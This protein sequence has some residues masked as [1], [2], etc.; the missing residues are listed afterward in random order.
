MTCTFRY[1]LSAAAE[2]AK[3]G[4]EGRENELRRW[5]KSPGLV[6]GCVFAALIASPASANPPTTTAWVE[7]VGTREATLKTKINPEGFATTYRVEWGIGASF[8]K[9]TEE[10]FVGSDNAD[11]LMSLFLDKLEP[12]TAYRW[13]VIATNATGGSKGKEESFRTF[14]APSPLANCPNEALRVGLS[15]NLPDCRAYE[16]V[17]PL[18][19]NGGNAQALPPAES[20]DGIYTSFKQSSFDGEKLTY[21]SGTAFGDAVAGAWANQYIATRDIDGWTTHGISPPRG[22]A[23]FEGQ[24]ATP[25]VNWDTENLFEAFTPDLCS[26]WVKDTNSE[27]LAPGGLTGY[28]NIY[29]RGNCGR[30]GYEALTM[31]GPFGPASEYLND[32]SE[33]TTPPPPPGP[34][35][36]FQ[37]YSADLTHQLFISGANLT[38]ERVRAGFKAECINTTLGVFPSSVSF[39][40][41]RNGVSID[42][43][44][45]PAYT[46]TSADQ[47]TTIQC[48]IFVSNASAGSTQIAVPPGGWVVAPVPESAPP[49]A[50]PTI[51]P[52]S[53]SAPLAVGGPGGQ[54]LTCDPK[55]KG[56]RG[57]P[58]FTYQWYRNGL[59]IVGATA[60]TYSV[61]PGDLATRA[62]F[63]CAVTG[64]NAG[65]A[66]VKVSANRATEPGPAK[67][68]APS[69]D[70][71]VRTKTQLYDLHDGKLELVSV[72]PSGEPNP[73]NSVAGTLGSRNSNR[74]STLGHAISADGSRIFWT[75]RSGDLTEGIGKLFV[76]IDG[77]RTLPVSEAVSPDGL[78][79]FLTAAKDGSSVLFTM[80]ECL[81]EFDVEEGLAETPEP[82]RQLACEVPGILGASDDLTYIYFVSRENLIP[83]AV[84]GM[85]N[86]Y[87]QK[88]GKITLVAS[89]SQQDMEAPQ[90]SLFRS[91]P[92]RRASRITP[93]GEQIV[94]QALATLTDYDNVDPVTGKRYTEVFHYDALSGRLTCV[95]CNPTGAP[96]SGGPLSLPYS[97]FNRPFSGDPN[98]SFNAHFGEA[99]TLPT[100]EREQYASRLLSENGDRVFFHSNE[101]LVARDV[102]GVRD[103]YQWEVQGTGTCK[104][105]DGCINLI[106]TGTSPQGSEF[107]DASAS[108]D[109]VFISTTSNIHPE[110]EGL[111]DIFDARVGGGFPV[112]PPPPECLGDACQPIAAAPNDPTPAGAI[113]RGSEGRPS[114]SKSCKALNQRA[115]RL[116]RRAKRTG[117]KPLAKSLRKRAM[118]L[119]RRAA[120]CRQSNRG[121]AR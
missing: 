34:G 54:V 98:S 92:I 1:R 53:T 81:Y 27:P 8:G 45:S 100:W 43:A 107:V 85:W 9:G 96:P 13:R 5:A 47:G 88:G 31:Q 30:E 76:R 33:I 36:R 41:L 117:S 97:A 12:G 57:G 80:D 104:E 49:V 78:A 24:P 69:A 40:W 64:T 94:F 66:S 86:L 28:V 14:D 2:V 50:P 20:T 105:G 22:T 74:E 101:A 111:V 46:V 106:S 99:A 68:P 71:R 51:T 109:D 62:V 59:A 102:N 79:R 115:A 10:I 17:S 90:I 7:D 91:D 119:N 25:L 95:S 6:L 65:G 110:D 38:S 82:E 60:S 114:R 67:P 121:G 77:E 35:L 4:S 19:K 23:V 118:R 103:V 108:G 3:H 83:G 72:L 11:H 48:Q 73:E 116:A 21:T 84:A 52:P 18:D 44:T 42:G 113:F 61:T 58:T 39:Q 55:E 37:G 120:R 26:A 70:A 75:S 56:W 16:M 63:Q 32:G 93:D 89:L 15:A 112:S 29:R 87:L